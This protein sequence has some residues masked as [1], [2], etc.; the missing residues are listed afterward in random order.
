MLAGTLCIIVGVLTDTPIKTQTKNGTP[1]VKARLAVTETYID[2]KGQDASTTNYFDVVTYNTSVM[3]KLYRDGMKGSQVMISGK[4]TSSQRQSRDG[5][6][7]YSIGITAN[8][9]SVDNYQFA[10]NRNALPSSNTDPA[11]NPESDDLPF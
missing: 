6:V 7:F 10:D 11:V 9:V 3:E 1:M 8:T 4:L 2:K 5:G